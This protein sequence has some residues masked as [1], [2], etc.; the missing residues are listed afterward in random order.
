ML[1][2]IEV[3]YHS[4]IKI[5]K[6]LIIYF[7]PYKIDYEYHDAD[8]IFITHS[9]YDHYSKEDI[10]KIKKENT[11]IIAP[12]DLYNK[13]LTLGF[14]EENIAIVQPNK[15]YHINKINFKTIP[16]YNINKNYH[17]KNNNWVGYLLTLNNITYYVAGDTDNTK[18]NRQVKCDIAFVPIGGT[19]TMDYKE[20]SELI[21]TIKPKIAI[22]TH[23]NSIV[24]TIED[25]YNFVNQLDRNIKYKLYQIK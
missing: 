9:H 16:A 7:D 24:G 8:I 6:K 19:F 4:S 17:P 23:Y 13:L 12:E 2:G 3:L 21:N 18:E 10:N 20:A 22:P 5:T 14:N 15:N 25:G 1:E 11:I